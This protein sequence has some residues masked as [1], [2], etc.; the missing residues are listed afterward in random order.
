MLIIHIHAD[1]NEDCT[2]WHDKDFLPIQDN[3]PDHDI[4]FPLQNEKVFCKSTSNGFYKTTLDE[5]LRSKRIKK[6]FGCG[7]VTSVC[8]LN[9]INGA[10]DRGYETF[11][12]EDCCADHPVDLH[13]LIIERYTRNH[14]WQ[15]VRIANA[16]KLVSPIV[17]E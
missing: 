3:P 7:L 10:Y 2:L 4:V 1:Y 14:T 11:L 12:I 15:P 5:Y 16:L 17:F 8:V 9:T 6:V 13:H